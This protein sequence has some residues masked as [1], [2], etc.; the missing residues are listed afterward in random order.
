MLATVDAGDGWLRT[1]GGPL[2]GAVMRTAAELATG[3]CDGDV[4]AEEAVEAA[5]GAHSASAGTRGLCATG[6]GPA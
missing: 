2:G 5:D 1:R 3:G 6:D 4:S